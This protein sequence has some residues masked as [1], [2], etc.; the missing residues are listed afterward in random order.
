M[1]NMQLI[2]YGYIFL[3]ILNKIKNLFQLPFKRSDEFIIVQVSQFDEKINLFWE[4]IKDDYDFILEKKQNFL[5]WRFSNTS[6][7]NHIK[8]QAVKGEEVLG[9]MVIGIKEDEGYTEGQIEDL[10]AL[11]NRLDVVYALFDYACKYLDK[12]GINTVY[13]QVVEKHPYQEISGRKEFID[14]GSKPYLQF[15]YTEN[16][17]KTSGET[18]IQFLK[19]TSPDRIYF[20]YAD[21]V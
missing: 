9:Y 12:L 7:G 10:L 21:T 18:E 17:Q 3:K 11:K 1:K 13:Y 5:N 20:N 6:K 15:S 8:I 19:N 4:K 14:S 16:Y 2:K